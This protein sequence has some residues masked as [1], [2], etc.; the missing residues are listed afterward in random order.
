VREKKL[1]SPEV[2]VP[3]SHAPGEAQADF[4]EAVVVIAG[5]E[6]KAHFMAFDL[7]HSD[8]CFVRAYPT[9]T[10][11]AFLDAHVHAFECFGGVPTC[12]LYHVFFGNKIG[13]MCRRPFCGREHE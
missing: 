6:Q 11:E 12:I 4:G 5:V 10:T 1:R 2:F 7:P 9:E 13:L 8:D 3:L